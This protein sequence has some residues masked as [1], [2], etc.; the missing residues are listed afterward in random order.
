MKTS[1]NPNGAKPQRAY[2][3]GFLLKKRTAAFS[4]W[5][6]L[7]LSMFCF[8]I[9]L[10][11]AVT[12]LTLNHTEWFDGKQVEKK[13]EGTMPLEWINNPDTS[14]IKK[15]E[16]VEFLR[17]QYG[18]T[19]YVSDFYIQDNDCSV[20]FKGPGYSADAFINREDGTFKMT[21]LKL[22]VFAVLNDL[23]KGRDSGKRWS[24]LI[25]ISAI[26]LTVVSLTGLVMLFFLKKKRMGALV[27]ALIG[28]VICYLIYKIFVP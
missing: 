1:S 13:F 25:D 7:Y 2:S 15:L 26:F 5:L 9:V 19:G 28:G 12:G 23:H 17:K 10:F 3:K 16:I 21:E 27:V 24:Y 6:H 4:R 8:L 11:F 22:G 14:K 20:S 18:I